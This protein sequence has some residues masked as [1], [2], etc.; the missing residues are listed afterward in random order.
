M[1]LI[2]HQQEFLLD[3]CKL[4]Q[5]ATEQG[6]VVTG[7][8]LWRS[9]EQQKI[10]VQTGRSKTMKSKH[11]NR[12]AIDLN[13]FKDGKIASFKDAE[14]LGNYWESLNPLNRWG[15]RFRTLVDQPHFERNV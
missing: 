15:G 1:S 14:I 2:K 8:E 11:L 9:P 3:V 6:F 12:V 5:Y 10:Y 4:V 13:I 7:G